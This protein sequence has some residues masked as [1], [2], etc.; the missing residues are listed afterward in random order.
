MQLLPTPLPQTTQGHLPDILSTSWPTLQARNVVF[1]ML[2][3]SPLLSIQP[4]TPWTWRWTPVRNSRESASS[5]RMKSSG[6]R[7]RALV[8]T[9]SHAKLLTV[10]NNYPHTSPGIGVHAQPIP[11]PRGS[12]RL[13]MGPSLAHGPKLSQC[14]RRQVEQVRSCDVLIPQ[15]ANNKD[16]VGCTLSGTRPSCI[17]SM[18]TI[19]RM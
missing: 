16:G 6:L 2:T 11:R 19:S 8:H 7:A 9:N 10:L 4:S 3:R 18:F 5:T 13:T 17:S 12:L 14:P 1:F 15:L